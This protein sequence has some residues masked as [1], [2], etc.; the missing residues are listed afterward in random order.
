M[1]KTIYNL[2]QKSYMSQEVFENSFAVIR[3]SKLAINLTNPHTFAG[4]FWT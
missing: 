3:K 2:Y 4:L 1:K